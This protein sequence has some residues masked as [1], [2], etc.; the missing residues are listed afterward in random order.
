MKILI[1]I[2]LLCLLVATCVSYS[3]ADEKGGHPGYHHI[4][5]GLTHARECLSQAKGE[6]PEQTREQEQAILELDKAIENIRQ[7]ADQVH[8]DLNKHIEEPPMPK[9][10]RYECAED[11]IR[12]SRTEAETGESDPIARGELE[13]ARRHMDEAHH[14]AEHLVAEIKRH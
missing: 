1:R 11:L 5:R 14:I 9:M 4:M 2:T 3:Q 10:H 12:R 8:Y 13:N 7:A 6:T